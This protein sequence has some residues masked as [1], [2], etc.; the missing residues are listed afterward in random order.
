MWGF[1]GVFGVF[2]VF[3]L[4]F[5][6]LFQ[7]YIVY[8]AQPWATKAVG[9][10]VLTAWMG[11]DGKICGIGIHQDAPLGAATALGTAASW[12]GPLAWQTLRRREQQPFVSWCGG[13]T[14][15]L[16]HRAPGGIQLGGRGID[17]PPEPWAGPQAGGGRT[18]CGHPTLP[19]EHNTR[20]KAPGS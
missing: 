3:F 20:G 17:A 18:C 7:G 8:M 16:P 9:S 11:S 1:G 15:H 19:G 12:P 4:N 6:L 13:G 2:F 10:R 5:S 14:C